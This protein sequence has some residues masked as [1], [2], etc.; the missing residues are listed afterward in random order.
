ML[1]ALTLLLLAQLLGETIVL[2]KIM[3]VAIEL[4]LMLAAVGEIVRHTGAQSFRLEN[5]QANRVR[6][7]GQFP[8]SFCAM[9]HWTPP[10]LSFPVCFGRAER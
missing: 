5:E 9:L 10:C 3:A 4:D 2:M 6:S 1:D 8:L 7:D